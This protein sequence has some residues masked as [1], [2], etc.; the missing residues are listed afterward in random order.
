MIGSVS[1]ITRLAFATTISIRVKQ[2]VLT[3][4]SRLITASWIIDV[5][6]AIAFAFFA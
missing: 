5:G 4:A 1:K 6:V 3:F 2:A